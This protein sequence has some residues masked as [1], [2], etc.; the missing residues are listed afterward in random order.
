MVEISRNVKICLDDLYKRYHLDYIPTDPIRSVHKFKDPRDQEIVGLIASSLAYGR[1]AQIQKSIETVLE[2]MGQKPYDFIVSFDPLKNNALSNFKHRFTTGGDIRYLLFLIKDMLHKDGSIEGFYMKGYSTDDE[3]IRA[4]LASFVKRA[5][6]TDYPLGAIPKG[7]NY[8]LPSPE[9]G[10]A[11]KRLNLFLRWMIRSDKLD[12]GLW[13]NIPAYKLI[14][15]LDT[16]IARLSRY[17]GLTDRAA[18]DWRMAKEITENLKA[19]DPHD[20]VKYDFALTRLGILDECKRAGD[21]N[22]S[23][24]QIKGICTIHQHR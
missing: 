19:I 5:L 1:V 9:K 8:L 2:A 21:N 11:C 20:P 6:Q 12:L 17:I 10:S 4:S 18:Q 7:I 22:C 3:D 23:L 13:K 24:C 15:P 16:H 14:I